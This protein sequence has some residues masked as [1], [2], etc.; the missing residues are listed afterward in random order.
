MVKEQPGFGQKNVGLP[1]L[2]GGWG[3][4][5]AVPVVTL[6]RI[7]ATKMALAWFLKNALY[8]AL[9]FVWL[10]SASWTMGRRAV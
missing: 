3:A 8:A 10:F 1:L 7:C 2:Q 4:S 6:V 9:G 5:L